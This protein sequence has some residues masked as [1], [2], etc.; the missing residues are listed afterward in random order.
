MSRNKNPQKSAQYFFSSKSQKSKFLT[1]NPAYGRQRISRP[2]RIVG[3]LQFWR[4]CVIYLI[5]FLLLFFRKITQP[6]QNCIGTTIRIGRESWCLPY[7]GF[8]Q[9]R[10]A[11]MSRSH[12]I[13]FKASHWLT[14]PQATSLKKNKK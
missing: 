8:S 12:V 6:L 1:K 4:G 13:F 3:P 2:M 11:G 7:A 14:P 10:L 5:F 9:N